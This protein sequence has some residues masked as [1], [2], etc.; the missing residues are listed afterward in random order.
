[1]DQHKKVGNEEMLS[2]IRHGADAVFSAKDSMFTEEDIETILA[3]GEKKVLC[4]HTH[5][6]THTYIHTHMYT[7]TRTHAHTHTCIH[8]HTT[9]THTHTHTY[10]HTHTHTHIHTYTHIPVLLF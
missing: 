10:T 8:T 6:H 2:M 3:R 7:Y 4:I 1:M 9:H 5:T